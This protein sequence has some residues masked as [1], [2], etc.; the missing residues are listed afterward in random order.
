MTV[1]AK[2]FNP[3]SEPPFVEVTSSARFSFTF[4]DLCQLVGP[5]FEIM[6][7]NSQFDVVCNDQQ[8][9]FNLDV[10][11]TAN[12]NFK[13]AFPEFKNILYG[14]VLVGTRGMFLQ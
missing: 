5:Y 8:D 11:D 3:E 2:L 4:E 9:D 13:E 14:T 7:I 6:S 1:T 10:L 12:A